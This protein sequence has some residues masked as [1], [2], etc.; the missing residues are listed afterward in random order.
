MGRCR[1]R[2]SWVGQPEELLKTADVSV[3]VFVCER[4]FGHVVPFQKGIGL[5]TVEAEDMSELMMGEDAPA[6]QVDGER[7][8]DGRGKVSAL[9]S[10]SFLNFRGQVDGKA[11]VHRV[12]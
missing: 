9:S 8:A 4:I 5:E 12:L 7:L 3:N 1:R 10:E 11:D 2:R 6:E